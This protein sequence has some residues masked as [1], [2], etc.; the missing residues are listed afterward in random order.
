MSVAASRLRRDAR[1]A[2][3]LHLAMVVAGMFCLAYVRPGWA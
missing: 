3:A 2:G 1:V